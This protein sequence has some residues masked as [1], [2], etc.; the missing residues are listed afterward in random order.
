MS[1]PGTRPSCAAAAFTVSRA[2]GNASFRYVKASATRTMPSTL[3][4]HSIHTPPR[5]SRTVKT[6]MRK[7]GT[8]MPSA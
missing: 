5:G 2:H 4:T 7:K 8:P 6:P 1:A 3:F